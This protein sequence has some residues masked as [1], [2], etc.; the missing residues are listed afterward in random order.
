MCTI[1]R[2][3]QGLRW[4]AQ[5]TLLVLT[6][7]AAWTRRIATS[8]RMSGTLDAG[9]L[10]VRFTRFGRGVTVGSCPATEICLNESVRQALP[11]LRLPA[12][13]IGSDE[14]HRGRAYCLS[15]LEQRN[16]GGIAQPVLQTRNVLWL[17]P[18]R[19]ST[20]S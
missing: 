13:S 14:I 10:N 3:E 19:S 9:L 6:T 11:L 15:Q 20:C 8:I 12:P 18:E 5:A 1:I 2:L 17:K 7:A 4:P 16:Y